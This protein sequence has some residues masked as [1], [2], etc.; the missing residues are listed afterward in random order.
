MG[1]YGK[2]ANS[3]KTA[4]SF[5]K[6]YTSRHE[7]DLNAQND[8]IFIGRYVVVEYDEPPVTAYFDGTAFYSTSDFREQSRITPRMGIIYQDLVRSNAPYTFYRWN[9]SN[10]EALASSISTSYA[11]YFN[12]DVTLYGRGY[13]STAWIKTF[14]VEHNNYRYVLIA[15]LNTVVPSFHLL[16]D[17]PGDKPSAP[18]FD[19]DTTNVDYYLHAQAE[20][21][22]SVRLAN[23]P[24]R[25]NNTA[26]KDVIAVSD[27]EITYTLVQWN[28]D[29]YGNQYF[30]RLTDQI[31]EG[32][33]YYNKAGFDKNLHT[34]ASPSITNTINYDLNYSGRKYGGGSAGASGAWNN[35]TMEQDMMEWYIHLPILGD[36]ICEV[37][38]DLYGVASNNARFTDLSSRRSDTSSTVTYNTTCV[39]G[40]IN[41]MRDMLGYYID[42]KNTVSAA[43]QQS[44]T[45]VTI[46]NKLYYTLKNANN[47]AEPVVDKYY[48]YTYDPIYVVATWNPSKQL[49]EYTSGSLSIV[50]TKDEVFFKDTDG[51]YKHPNLTDW[52]SVMSDG[53]RIGTQYE[54]LYLA[55]DAWRMAELQEN[56]EDSIYGMLVRLNRLSGLYSPDIRDEN[57]LMGC[58]NLVKDMIANVDKHMAPYKMVVTN[59]NG[60]L[61]T[62]NTEY[63]Y[64]NSMSRSGVQSSTYQSNSG[65]VK[66]QEI[67]GSNGEWH[68][69]VWY[70]LYTLNIHNTTNSAKY[71][72]EGYFGNSV[73]NELVE[74]DTIGD[75]FYKLSAD[76][77]DAAYIE[78]Q[79]LTFTASAATGG[80]NFAGGTKIENGRNISNVTLNYTMNKGERQT[81]TI[82]RVN[83]SANVYS[84][85]VAADFHKQS[86]YE[87]SKSGT[88]TDTNTITASGLVNQVLRWRIT[89]KDERDHTATKEVTLQY[90]SKV[91]W[92]V[93]DKFDVAT[94]FTSFANW[95][96]AVTGGGN[97]LQTTINKTFTVNPAA[98]KYIYYAY[99]TTMGTPHFAVG[100]IQGGFISLG[101]V[102]F[103]NESGY[104]TSYTI[105][106]SYRPT[107]GTTIVVVS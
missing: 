33:I 104:A 49:Y 43:N 100:G 31:G 55:Q 63:P 95:N 66:Y 35:G 61:I 2:I 92:G 47:P 64:F 30:D 77:A 28:G 1:F 85:N 79:I 71:F 74:T 42:N 22:H 39:Y 9:G 62:S 44:T 45:N 21:G 99:P 88:V 50:G 40:A 20:W 91:Y 65:A 7:M 72:A 36:T 8:G 97:S 14:D 25:K 70:R 27:E 29:V 67:L 69:P 11:A 38:D 93:G 5:D 83:P 81:L 13:D 90:M 16:V 34:K 19:R 75:A 86:G 58:I 53:S 23:K 89:V 24:R 26:A 17:A 37:W 102:N 6:V 54:T 96:S 73:R 94:S 103:T 32:D 60:T 56:L 80:E 48:F 3:N 41:K 12:T 15:E 76:V 57:S 84:H 101:S 18:Y 98:D 78:P 52:P 51:Y 46:A 105:W 107:L 68:L 59:Q 87:A 82:Q 10:Y 106:R 4:F